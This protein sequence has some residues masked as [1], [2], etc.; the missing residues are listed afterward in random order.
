MPLLKLRNLAM[1]SKTL[2]YR[3]YIIRVV[4]H[5]LF[6]GEDLSRCLHGLGVGWY[7]TSITIGRYGDDKKLKE[8]SIHAGKLSI[9]PERAIEY[10]KKFAIQV[11]DEE[12]FNSELTSSQSRASLEGVRRGRYEQDTA[13]AGRGCE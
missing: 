13:S 6:H 7:S 10:G 11:I 9:T 2:A 4:T 12:I 3:G 1:A 5:E 8:E